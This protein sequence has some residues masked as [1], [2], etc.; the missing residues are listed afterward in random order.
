MSLH[1]KNQIPNKPVKQ[2]KNETLQLFKVCVWNVFW[3]CVQMLFR[4]VIG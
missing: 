1:K 3:P 4:N 2:N